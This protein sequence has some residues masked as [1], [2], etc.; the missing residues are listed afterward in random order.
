MSLSII[1]EILIVS[2]SLKL[3]Q[4][5]DIAWCLA[6]LTECHYSK[7]YEQNADT[8]TNMMPTLSHNL[9]TIKHINKEQLIS[10]Q[11]LIEALID[12]TWTYHPNILTKK[13]LST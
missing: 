4:T 2:A 3:W 10:T 9:K 13:S 11:N 5:L 8:A 1:F 7:K 6:T 12:A